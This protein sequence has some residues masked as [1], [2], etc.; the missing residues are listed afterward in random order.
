LDKYNLA[1]QDIYNNPNIK[2]LAKFIDSNQSSS[3]IVPNLANLSS[4]KILNQVRPF[5]LSTVL[6]TGVTGFLGIHLLRDLL[7]N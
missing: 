1:I 3:D 2:D 6:L 7:L 4:C 5:D